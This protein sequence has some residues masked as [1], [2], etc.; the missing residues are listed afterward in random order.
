MRKQTDSPKR[1]LNYTPDSETSK[2][3]H[4][5]HPFTKGK[6]S[7]R[8]PSDG[9]INRTTPAQAPPHKHPTPHAKSN[10]TIQRLRPKNFQQTDTIP[11]RTCPH[12]GILQEVRQN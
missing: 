8:G 11:H 4:S 2:L 3:K 1:G 7:K 5:W 10:K 9:I 6:C 12:W